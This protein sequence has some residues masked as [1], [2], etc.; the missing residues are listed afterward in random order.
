MA[1][2]F[3]IRNPDYALGV[4]FIFGGLNPLGCFR[5]PEYRAPQE[6]HA[7]VMS[8]GGASG[9]YRATGCGQNQTDKTLQTEQWVDGTLAR[10]PLKTGLRI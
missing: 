8:I 4:C 9:P 6:L 5:L 1:Y 2:G 10:D 7:F 3:C